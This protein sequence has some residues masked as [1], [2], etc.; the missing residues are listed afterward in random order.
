M[1]MEESFARVFSSLGRTRLGQAKKLVKSS[2]AALGLESEVRYDARNDVLEGASKHVEQ[3]WEH[4]K[5][6][7]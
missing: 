6:A 4:M 7:S 3:I 2:I 5:K 1:R